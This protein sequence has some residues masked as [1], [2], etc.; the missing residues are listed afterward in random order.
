MAGASDGAGPQAAQDRQRLLRA[1]AQPVH[2]AVH[3]EPSGERPLEAS[4]LE[5]PHLARLVNRDL[6][7][8][9][10]AERQL[11]GLE[12]AF[13]EQD[14]LRRPGLAQG[15]RLLDAGDA[16]HV[17]AGQRRQQASGT[18]AVAVGLDDRDYLGPGSAYPRRRPDCGAMPR[19][20]WW[21]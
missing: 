4:G 3:L 10:R 2:A 14:R 19:G 21:R 5:H 12:H 11:V 13:Q 9:P 1:E 8:L 20:R 18:V 16:Q 15:Q 7:A 6:E 17:G